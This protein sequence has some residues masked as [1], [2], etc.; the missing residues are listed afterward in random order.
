M[1][2][3]DTT[4]Q[5]TMATATITSPTIIP[6]ASVGPLPTSVLEAAPATT[7]TSTSTDVAQGPGS[8]SLPDPTQSGSDAIIQVSPEI[9]QVLSMMTSLDTNFEL[10]TAETPSSLTPTQTR[11][12]TTASSTGVIPVSNQS[13]PPTPPPMNE[14]AVTFLLITGKRRTMSFPPSTT[15]GRVKE[16][17][18]NTWPADWSDDRPPTPNYLR[19]LYLGKMLQDEEV[20]ETAL[21]SLLPQLPSGS[22]S[23]PT[24]VHISIRP[25]A[26]STVGGDDLKKKK[27]LGSGVVSIGRVLEAT[28]IMRGEER[29]TQCCCVIC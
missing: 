3:T 23:S 17:V 5:P 18:W 8:T 1:T 16:L 21:H 11:L 10:S 26:P 20:L 15:L 2:E 12:N 24:I 22:S 25:V 29:D 19:I 7:S 27:R 14:I 13:S 6:M 4:S 28:R 9:S